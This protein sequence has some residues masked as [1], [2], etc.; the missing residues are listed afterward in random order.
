MTRWGKQTPS[1]SRNV[2]LEDLPP[3]PREFENVFIEAS[4]K[5]KELANTI[6]DQSSKHA[7]KQ[8]GASDNN[9]EGE[10][11]RITVEV[12]VPAHRA[13]LVIGHHG[14]SLKRIEKLSQC[15]V[16]FDQQFSSEH[17]R[18]IIIVGIPEDI[19]E[20]KRLIKEKVDDPMSRFP[21]IQVIVP[22]GRVGLVIGKGGET[23]R[24][25]QEKS[26]AKITVQPET[27]IESYSTERI[28]NVTGDEESIRRAKELINDL[29]TGQSKT[30]GGGFIG[31]G[32]SGLATARNTTTIQIPETSV[33]A[34]I[35]KR[36]ETLKSLQSMSGCRI[37]VEPN[38]TAGNSEGRNVHLTGA[39]EQ[40]AYAQQLIMEKVAQCDSSL[41]TYDH[42]NQPSVIYQNPGEFGIANAAGGAAS[43]AMDPASQAAYDYSQ[44]YYYYQQQQQQPQ[45]DS[46]GQPIPFDYSSYYYYNQQQQQQPQEQGQGQG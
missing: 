2:E 39:P 4:R 19:E 32:S 16:Q 38:S 6:K 30:G 12:I 46:Q 29:L 27:N 1:F 15:K 18:K 26:G 35:G 17:E 43:V 11:R 9:L 20:A 7:M 14:E 40:I 31:G 33:G 28:V 8:F 44:Y 45:V 25:L 41:Y 21:T 36:A 42:T 13:G 22:Q 24:E 10:S 37:F 3:L 34:I 5:L 23:I